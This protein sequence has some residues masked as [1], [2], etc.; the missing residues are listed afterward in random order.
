FITHLEIYP[1]NEAS[2]RVYY[3]I[4]QFLF[5]ECNAQVNKKVRKY[6]LSHAIG[7]GHPDVIKLLIAKGVSV[8]DE[9]RDQLN[10]TLKNLP[11]NSPHQQALLA[12]KAS[13]NLSAGTTS[14]YRTKVMAAAVVTA[15]LLVIGKVFY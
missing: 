11:T 13:W 3:H 9:H 8:T 1:T 6:A 2:L 5:D 14:T 10:N 15:L 12:L 7:G 4:V